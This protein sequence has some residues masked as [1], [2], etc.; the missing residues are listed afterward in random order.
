L[1]LRCGVSTCAVAL[2]GGIEMGHVTK[3][4]ALLLVAGFLTPVTTAAQVSIKGQ[5]R[6]HDVRQTWY[7]PKFSMLFGVTSGRL[8]YSGVQ[9]MA[10]LRLQLTDRATFR[11][12]G[13]VANGDVRGAATLGSVEFGLGRRLYSVL[14]GGLHYDNGTDVVFGGG[15]GSTIDIGDR[16]AVIEVRYLSMKGGAIYWSL[17]KIF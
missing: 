8:G 5:E 15:L 16:R 9:G 1:S 13:V 11:G 12:E 6:N 2:L 7:V 3:R 4:L 14:G 10:A 17:G